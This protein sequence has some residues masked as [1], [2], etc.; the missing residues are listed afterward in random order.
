MWQWLLRICHYPLT[1]ENPFAAICK[2]PPALKGAMVMVS[3][4]H[5]GPGC[6]QV[7][8]VGVKV[9]LPPSPPTNTPTYTNK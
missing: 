4:A 9:V 1:F 2:Y 8:T 3:K 5:P 7:Y 6:L